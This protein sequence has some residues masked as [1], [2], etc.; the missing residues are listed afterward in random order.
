M[1]KSLRN[2]VLLVGLIF[3]LSVNVNAA[4]LSSCEGIPDSDG[5]CP[6][7]TNSDR[8][9][10]FLGGGV[11]S[12]YE[13]MTTNDTLTNLDSGKMIIVSPTAGSPITI[14]LP[15]A[16]TDSVGMELTFIQDDTGVTATGYGS[17]SQKYFWIDPSDNDTIVYNTTQ[18]FTNTMDRGD[19]LVSGGT[20]GDSIHLICGKELFWY[21]E[22]SRGTWTDD[23]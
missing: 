3:A 21:V 17:A 1:L 13:F 11:L 15:S 14:A 10:S 5:Y 19:K 22:G 7:Q 4:S 23:N 6:I 20:T 16:T 2:L 9:V 18:G 8:L 12:K